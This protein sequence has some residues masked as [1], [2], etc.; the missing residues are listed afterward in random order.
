MFSNLVLMLPFS[1]VFFILTEPNYLIEESLQQPTSF[2][3]VD[4]TVALKCGFNSVKHSGWKTKPDYYTTSKLDHIIPRVNIAAIHIFILGYPEQS[5]MLVNRWKKMFQTNAFKTS[6][7]DHPQYNEASQHEKTF[8]DELKEL[9]FGGVSS[10]DPKYDGFEQ[11]G[12]DK[13]NID[14]NIDDCCVEGKESLMGLIF[15]APYIVSDSGHVSRGAG[16]PANNFDYEAIP[17]K[18][19]AQY[20]NSV[21][22]YKELFI[23]SE[24]I[25]LN[26]LR[27][28]LK[29]KNVSEPGNVYVFQKLEA[30]IDDWEKNAVAVVEMK[31][32][33]TKTDHTTLTQHKK[34]PQNGCSVHELIANGFWTTKHTFQIPDDA[35]TFLEKL[36]DYLV[37]HQPQEKNIKD[38]KDFSGHAEWIEGWTCLPY[39]YQQIKNRGI[40]VVLTEGEAKLKNVLNHFEITPDLEKKEIN[41]RINNIRS[42]LWLQETVKQKANDDVLW[43]IEMKKKNAPRFSGGPR[44]ASTICDESEKN[45]A[46]KKNN[47]AKP[48]REI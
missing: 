31:T 7:I 14:D 16:D 19:S 38:I 27:Q 43:K 10:A 12:D 28:D 17:Y 5:K 45:S 15:Y 20:K 25:L 36:P 23:V 34:K 46:S 37:E 42:G 40:H 11:A 41:Q 21:K 30:V 6:I 18:N 13:H 1:A 3:M 4:K 2:V 24:S 35:I 33:H 48:K 9:G 32:E 8:Y 29:E 26:R 39:L 44:T 22:L 47:K